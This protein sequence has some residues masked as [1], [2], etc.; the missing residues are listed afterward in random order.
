VFEAEAAAKRHETTRS[1]RRAFASDRPQDRSAAGE[2]LALRRMID[3]SIG[4][5]AMPDEGRRPMKV[6]ALSGSYREGGI[7]EQAIAAVLAGA[8]A[9]GA[10]VEMVRLADRR[11]EFCNNCRQCMQT[12]GDELGV[13]TLPEDDMEALL[14]ACAGADVLVVAAP[15]NIGSTTALMKRFI[16]RLAPTAHWPWGQPAPG[17]RNW[18]EKKRLAAV[19]ITSSAAPS[20]LGRIAGF[21]GLKDLRW[22][23][24]SFQARVV[25]TRWYGLT[26][27]D[28]PPE[29]GAKRARDAEALGR[30]VVRDERGR[31][32]RR[33]G[34]RA[35]AT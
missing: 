17:Y 33:E 6:L 19:L 4:R 7:T 28:M 13:C 21:S 34:V 2:S 8:K 25:A 31:A 9:E 18:I 15:V 27:Q 10:E 1:A 30:K 20:V 14:A 11:I 24:R 3:R 26:A 5:A 29:L 23:A 35:R 32:L 12:P 22:V 16:E